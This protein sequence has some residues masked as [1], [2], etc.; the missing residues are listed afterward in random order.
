M[1]IEKTNLT[2]RS[3]H[4]AFVVSFSLF[5]NKGIGKNL[6]DAI[7]ISVVNGNFIVKKVLSD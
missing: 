5:D 6:Y 2:L 4:L 3:Y 1:G 7:V